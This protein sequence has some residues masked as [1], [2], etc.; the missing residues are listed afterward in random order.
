M[1]KS[2]IPILSVL[3]I[4]S[5][6]SCKKDS[7]SQP[8]EQQEV[9]DTTR[10]VKTSYN[11]STSSTT[12]TM[13]FEYDKSGKIISL[14]DSA[15]PSYYVTISYNG[16]EVTFQESPPKQGNYGY[17]AHYKLN[18]NRLPVQRITVEGMDAM[19]ATY[20]RF[21][22]HTDTC[23]YEYDAAG[24]LVKATGKGYDSTWSKN[25]ASPYIRSIRKA[26]TTNYTNKDGKLMSVKTLGTEETIQ[27]IGANTYTD[28][29]NTEEN[30][31]F[32]Y[33]KNYLN[34]SDSIN[35]WLFVELDL[36]YSSKFPMI[37]YA[38]LPDKMRHTTKSTDPATGDVY[39]N[40]DESYSVE[41]EY[42]PSGY[43][44][45]VKFTD[46]NYWDKTRITYN[47]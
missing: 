26:Y 43:I 47:K 11:H 25:Q 9:A 46:G 23:K 37:K 30:Y 24:L 41:L 5:L 3:F 15:D 22:I 4:I 21:E 1:K 7:D 40:S 35:A 29:M 33:T 19:S 6:D 34:K 42:L 17:R 38:N 20:P 10:V 45:S 31:S 36:L 32:E 12:E 39:N 27:T 13:F 2:L 44:S 18:G 14:K 8:E 28:A 16:D